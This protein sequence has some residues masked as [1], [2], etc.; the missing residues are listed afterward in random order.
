MACLDN[1]ILVQGNCGTAT[2]TSG[3]F[4]NTSLA[5]I[6]LKKAANASEGALQTGVA[7]LNQAITNGTALAQSALVGEMLSVVRFNAIVSGSKYGKQPLDP[8]LATNYA[9]LS[10]TPRGMKFELNNCCPLTEICIREVTMLTASNTTGSTLTILDGGTTTTFTFNTTALIETTIDVNYT[11]LTDTVYLTANATSSW[12]VSNSRLNQ[13]GTCGFCANDCCASPTCEYQAGLTP[14]GY[15]GTNT[16]GLTY[17]MTANINVV[18]SE[19]KFICQLT[20]IP[21]FAWLVLYH[22]GVWF[23]D[24]LVMSNRI[25]EYTIYNQEQAVIR[26]DQW[27]E[28]ADILEKKLTKQLPEYLLSLDSCCIECN[29]SR[30]DTATP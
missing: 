9:A 10:D 13:S 26:A 6:T 18:C 12:S 23:L 16:T 27:R 17:G 21:D 25:N 11:V 5:G 14:W 24:Y 15:D 30:W 22:S 2:P 7:L 19:R 28:Q 1:F 8:S 20:C 29:S 3:L 4:I